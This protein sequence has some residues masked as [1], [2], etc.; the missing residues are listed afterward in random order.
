MGVAI[1][2]KSKVISFTPTIDTSAYADGDQLGDL[3]ELAEAMDSS[4]DTGLVVSVVVVDKDKDSAALDVLFFND[5]PTV[6]SSDNAA[7]D[8]A[9]S[10]MASKFLGSVRVAAAD[11]I[12]LNSSTVA[13]VKNVNLV[14]KSEKSA[15]NLDGKSLWCILRSAGTPTYT[16]TSDLVVKIGLKQD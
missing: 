9:D 5:K 12:A 6:S 13:T 14:V 11:Y 8:I 3:K 16:A 15:D 4:G 2:G 7:L 10:E 1:E